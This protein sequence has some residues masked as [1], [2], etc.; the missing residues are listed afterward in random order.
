VVKESGDCFRD[1]MVAT[2]VG[3]GSWI[4]PLYFKGQVANAPKDSGRRPDSNAK[5]EKGMNNRAMKLYADHLNKHVNRQCLLILDRHSSHT[6]KVTREYFK[7]FKLQDGSEKFKLMLL[8]PKSAFLISPCDMGF[9]AMWKNEFYKYDRSTYDLKI[10]AADTAWRRMKKDKIANLF[11]HCG[12]TSTEHKSTLESRIH[13]EVRCGVPEKLTQIWKFYNKWCAG[14]IDVEG[15][16]LPRV[17]PFTDPTS[18]PDSH[19]NG[20]HWTKWG[21]HR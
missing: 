9:F 17:V 13:S 1:T 6:S 18:L 4:P 5:I 8:P 12:L 11:I 3:D 14:L 2:L 19:L 15:V 7:S 10:S 16:N 21:Y 20:S